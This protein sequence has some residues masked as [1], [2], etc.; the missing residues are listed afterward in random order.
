M[1]DAPIDGSAAS[2]TPY[3]ALLVYEIG[4]PGG[5]GVYYRE[6]FVLIRAAD[7]EQARVS[8]EEHAAREVAQFP[9]GSYV[10]LHAVIDVNEALEPLDSGP[11]VDLYSRHFA[12]IEDYESFEMFRGGKDPFE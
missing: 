2:G 4:K 8:A 6:D 5:L 7:P 9:D 12:R 1:T 3:L 11:T 10:E